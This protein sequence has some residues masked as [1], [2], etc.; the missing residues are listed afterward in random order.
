MDAVLRDGLLLTQIVNYLRW[1]DVYIKF[2]LPGSHFISQSGSSSTQP[3]LSESR[4]RQLYG[5]FD[6]AGDV[7]AKRLG[8]RVYASFTDSMLHVSFTHP[9]VTAIARLA[10]VDK[11]WGCCILQAVNQKMIF[12]PFP[13]RLFGNTTIPTMILSNSEDDIDV[14]TDLTNI[15]NLEHLR[16]RCPHP[17]LWA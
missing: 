4:V 6:Q 14:I 2:V 1:Q 15:V 3:A 7:L 9:S 5:H 8:T 13:T 12:E 16:L 11:F 10:S 17:V